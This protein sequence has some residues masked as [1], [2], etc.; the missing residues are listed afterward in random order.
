M[1]TPL[2]DK[3]KVVPIRPDV[4]PATERLAA[5]FERVRMQGQTELARELALRLTRP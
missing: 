5:W 2:S 4:R 3:G 1:T